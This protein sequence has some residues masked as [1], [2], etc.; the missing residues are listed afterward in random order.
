MWGE[1]GLVTTFLL[2]LMQ[3]KDNNSS[4]EF[5]KSVYRDDNKDLNFQNADALSFSVLVEPDFS[6]KGFG[7]SDAVFVIKFRNGHKNIFFLDAKGNTYLKSQ[8]NSSE[9]DK[10]GYNSSINGQLE[11]NYCLSRTLMNF[12]E[13]AEVLIAPEWMLKTGYNVE[14]KGQLR[15]LKNKAVIDSVV[16]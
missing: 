9:R 14:R 1:R 2:D 16:S 5:M 4:L 11:L 13:G 8:N 15:L 3:C 12:G 10:E 6:N 7:H